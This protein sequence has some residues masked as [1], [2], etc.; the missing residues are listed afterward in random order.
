M[1]IIGEEPERKSWL[2]MLPGFL[3]A[4]ASDKGAGSSVAKAQ[5]DRMA[6]LAD[7]GGEALNALQDLVV[8]VEQAIEGA[9]E[10]KREF[11][12]IAREDGIPP[13][14]DAARLVLF[15]VGVNYGG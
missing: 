1:H 11:E 9:D 10:Q 15:K 7:L 4:Y 12:Q 6:I 13:S 3:L 2:K 8:H 14:L 5:L